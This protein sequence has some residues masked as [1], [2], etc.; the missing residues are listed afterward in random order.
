MERHHSDHHDIAVILKSSTCKPYAQTMR[1]VF[2][3]DCANWAAY[4]DDGAHVMNVHGVKCVRRA[5]LANGKYVYDDDAG[6]EIAT[7]V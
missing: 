2:Y 3:Y 6:N 7:N 1:G 4:N 5:S